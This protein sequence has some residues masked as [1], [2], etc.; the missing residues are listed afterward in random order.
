MLFLIC[1]L[2]LRDTL[3]R[4]EIVEQQNM[5]YCSPLSESYGTTNTK[6]GRLNIRYKNPLRNINEHFKR[7]KKYS[8]DEP[9][10]TSQVKATE[11]SP[12][13]THIHQNETE[14]ADEQRLWINQHSTFGNYSGRSNRDIATQTDKIIEIDRRTQTVRFLDKH[15]SKMVMS[16][17]LGNNTIKRSP[18]SEHDDDKQVGS[19]AE[20]MKENES[21][22]VMKE[23]AN[24]IQDDICDKD[25]IYHS[26]IGDEMEGVDESLVKTNRPES[27]RTSQMEKS[28]AKLVGKGK[29]KSR[30]SYKKQSGE[31]KARKVTEKQ[32]KFCARLRKIFSSV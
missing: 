1:N 11:D 32:D 9:D 10:A 20:K 19:S 7:I 8:Y 3:A 30:G 18:L 29:G 24:K 16:E 15:F 4:E 17:K 28:V 5:V 2:F 21:N 25:I 27:R 13:D 22:S 14:C 23:L 6:N 26:N 12:A 31:R